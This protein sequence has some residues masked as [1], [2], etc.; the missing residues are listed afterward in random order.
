MATAKTRVNMRGRCEPTGV[1]SGGSS[2]RPVRCRCSGTSITGCDAILVGDE[3]GITSGA[4]TCALCRPDEPGGAIDDELA[5]MPSM[6]WLGRAAIGA[7]PVRPPMI[8][9]LG[10]DCA[11]CAEVGIAGVLRRDGMPADIGVDIDEVTTPELGIT[12]ALCRDGGPI[13]GELRREGTP[14]GIEGVLCR[15]GM[16]GE[17]GRSPRPALA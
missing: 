16:A 11:D 3:L 10:R 14:L 5:R 4:I 7:E 13:T 2:L 9:W 8:G 6:G 1:I 17:L 12:G 15:E